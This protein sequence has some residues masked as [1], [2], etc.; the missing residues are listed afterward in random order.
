M[1]RARLLAAVIAVSMVAAACGDDGSSAPKKEAA[2]TEIRLLTHDSF[3]VSKPLLGEFRE[4]TGIDIRIVAAGDAGA[5]VNQ[6]VLTKGKPLGDVFFG[7]DNTF[8]SR[9][10]S[11]DIFLPYESPE[12]EQVDDRY[13]I[14]GTHRATP[15][16]HGEVC[17]NYDKAWFA[18]RGL[19]V[20]RTL[21]DL[22]APKYKGLLVTENPATSS[23]GLAFLLATV[24]RFGDSPSAG[25]E[26]YWRRLKANDV[27]VTA[28]WEE[29]YNGSFSGSAGKGPRPLVVSYA[30]SPPAEVHFA[31]PKPANAP[32]GVVE[33]TCF[34]QIEFAGILKGTKK[35]AAA[36]QVIDFLLSEKFQADIPLQMFVFPVRTA[37]PL[38]EVFV[39]HAA[40]PDAPIDL[41]PD[42]I[43][44][45]RERWISRWTA[46]VLQ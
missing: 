11:E 44:A 28:G 35:A 26:A 15:V 4:Q 30:S 46:L 14:D 7:V 43:G 32:T 36:K 33:D 37:T 40:Q 21:E 3:A 2:R 27:E 23:P 22:A 17:V 45:G 5:V 34:R 29:A 41:A 16:D 10:L 13:E 18:Q 38:P 39:K 9:A 1:S 24:A 12:L 25:W 42:R 6:A 8:L 20:P 19:A 31:D